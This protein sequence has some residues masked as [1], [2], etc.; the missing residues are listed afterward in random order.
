MAGTI[1]TVRRQRPCR[2]R[3]T[4]PSPGT[5]TMPHP[6]P[7]ARSYPA[8]M[9][10]TG[11]R[12]A[13]TP[14]SEHSRF[15]SDTEQALRAAG[16]SPER[17]VDIS[18]WREFFQASGFAPN[19]VVEGFL[20]EFGGLS[21]T[22]SGPGLERAREPFKI[23]PVLLDGEEERFQEW[24][25]ELGVTLYPIGELNYG[26]YFLGMDEQGRLYLVVDWVARW[27]ALD[28]G[29]EDLILGRKPVELA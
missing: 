20:A 29:L 17:R 8:I 25:E 27:S 18:R 13:R 12:R 19:A 24:G 28:K 14:M 21:V 6:V 2:S 7:A 5:G 3:M 15:T 23:D 4:P 22:I 1:H 9:A 11:S 10:S 26:H 16:W